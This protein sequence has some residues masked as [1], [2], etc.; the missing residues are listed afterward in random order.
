MAVDY[1]EDFLQRIVGV[2]WR[3]P[4]GE[5]FFVFGTS[6]GRIY[7][8]NVSESM[9]PITDTSDRPPV[10]KQVD[11]DLFYAGGSIV[12]MSVGRNVFVAIGN[13]VGD[14]FG[15]NSGCQIVASRDGLK[16][17]VVFFDANIPIPGYPS[18]FHS[19]VP[20]GIVWDGQT[21]HASSHFREIIFSGNDILGNPTYSLQDEGEQMYSS[22]DGFAWQKTEKLGGWG[23]LDSRN[24][25]PSALERYCVKPQN[26]NG[27]P[28]GL[29][30]YS[31]V[32]DTLAK[33]TSLS[34]F[35][36]LGGAVY[37]PDPPAFTVTFSAPSTSDI[38]KEVDFECHAVGFSE[39]WLAV[40]KKIA[41]AGLHKSFKTIFE[42]SD[43][44]SATC[45]IG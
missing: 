27:M 29:Q 41:L 16:W 2:Q 10:F 33:P 7:C 1:G 8:G 22:P 19:T 25:I 32:S 24:Q 11:N 45:V 36:V 15:P 23:D 4:F 3:K 21:F 42:L 40:G 31:K 44:D 12:G 13:R 37:D 5:G 17:S 34:K 6:R 18:S 38:I 43:S 28:D 30:A 9:P 39:V 20:V 14:F 35:Y 26:K